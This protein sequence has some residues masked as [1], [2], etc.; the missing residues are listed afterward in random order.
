VKYNLEEILE[1]L[2]KEKDFWLTKEVAEAFGVSQR[3]IQYAA[4]REKIGTKVRSGPHGTYVFQL[5]DLQ[6]LCEAVYGEVGNPIN[7]SKARARGSKEG[8]QELTE[9]AQVC[10]QLRSNNE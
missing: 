3:A 1:L 7:I 9:D 4:K 10:S 6:R 5:E 2:P 8:S